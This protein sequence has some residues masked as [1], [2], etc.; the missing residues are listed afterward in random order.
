MA[1]ISGWMCLWST[2]ILLDAFRLS[3]ARMTDRGRIVGSENPGEQPRFRYD[4]NLS[5]S[6]I[7]P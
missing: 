5:L 2:P 6:G 7:A 4:D 1:A 3:I